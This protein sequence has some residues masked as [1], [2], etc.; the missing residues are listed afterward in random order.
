VIF[1][2][3]HEAVGFTLPGQPWGQRWRGVFDTARGWTEREG[4]DLSADDSVLA[5][6]RSVVLLRRLE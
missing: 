5:E 6:A 1:N 3:H 2:A 4:D